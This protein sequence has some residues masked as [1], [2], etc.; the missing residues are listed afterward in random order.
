MPFIYILYSESIDQYYVGSTK[1]LEDRIF[2]H[3]NSGSKATKKAD[4]WK[5]VYTESYNSKSEASRREL[6]I[7]RN[8]VKNILSGFWLSKAKRPESIRE[9][10]PERFRGNLHKFF[11]AHIFCGLYLCM[12]TFRKHSGKSPRTISG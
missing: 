8:K 9:G 3:N 10:H 11:K 6:E 4:D 2:R 12:T 1:D 7:K 5:L